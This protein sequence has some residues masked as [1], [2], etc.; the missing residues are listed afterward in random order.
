[1]QNKLIS[2]INK[3]T[4]YKAGVELDIARN[5]TLIYGTYSP[6]KDLGYINNYRFSINNNKNNF[7]TFSKLLYEQTYNKLLN[8]N[9]RTIPVGIELNGLHKIVIDIDTETTDS[10]QIMFP[11]FLEVR[12]ILKQ[13]FNCNVKIFTREPTKKEGII[14]DNSAIEGNSYKYGCHIIVDKYI[15][16]E[17][18][19]CTYIDIINIPRIKELIEKYGNNFIDPAV[20]QPHHIFWLFGSCKDGSKMYCELNDNCSLKNPFG[21]EYI[22]LQKSFEQFCIE[23]KNFEYYVDT[24][25]NS[26]ICNLK[27]E[28]KNTVKKDVSTPDLFDIPPPNIVAVDSYDIYTPFHTEQQVNKEVVD[29][30]KEVSSNNVHLDIK[31]LDSLL[32]L[33]DPLS[34]EDYPNVRLKI[35][36]GVSREYN[37]STESWE[38]LLKYLQLWNQALGRDINYHIEPIKKSFFDGVPARE[39]GISLGTVRFLAS[40]QNHAKYEEWCNDVF[41]I[42]FDNLYNDECEFNDEGLTSNE[43]STEKSSRVNKINSAIEDRATEKTSNIPY[44]SVNTVQTISRFN[45]KIL[46]NIVKKHIKES[47]EE[48]EDYINDRQQ[49]L[50]LFIK[51]FKDRVFYLK[52]PAN[53]VYIDG[54]IFKKSDVL[55]TYE[56]YG[57]IP[58]IKTFFKNSK[59]PYPAVDA[60]SFMNKCQYRTL[61]DKSDFI[62]ING[63]PSKKIIEQDG[64]KILNTFTGYNPKIYSTEQIPDLTKYETLIT[65]FINYHIGDKIS[66]ENKDYVMSHPVWFRLFALT[67]LNISGSIEYCEYLK[68]FIAQIIQEPNTLLPIGLLFHSRCRQGKGLLIKMISM[69]IGDDYVIE[70]NTKEDLFGTHAVPFENRLLVNINE[71]KSTQFGQDIVDIMKSYIDGDKLRTANRKNI[72]QYEYTIKARII[73]TTNNLNGFSFDTENGNHRFNAF[74]SYNYMPD[75]EIVYNIISKTIDVWKKSKWF[76]RELYNYFNTIKFTH[77]EVLHIY[78]TPYLQAIIDAS[79]SPVKTWLD[80]LNNDETVINYYKT[81]RKIEEISINNIT[82]D[83]IIPAKNLWIAFN[84][85]CSD[86]YISSKMTS[87]SFYLELNKYPEIVKKHDVKI[88]NLVCYH[89]LHNKCE[90]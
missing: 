24:Y 7:L 33:I 46:S 15:Y 70:C 13:Y 78:N 87:K 63:I 37:Q 65:E 32:A 3:Q 57:K 68:K 45:E 2:F 88:H 11:I 71:A 26:F 62:P 22:Q 81:S 21:I 27:K 40:E 66:K 76:Y 84:R 17:D 72:Q 73:A 61:C 41:G 55:S 1:M 80:Q 52:Y 53:S 69:I 5:N 79:D 28:S 48:E 60:F 64:Y 74:T 23:N 86:S 89:L 75:Q 18:A 85:F 20:F 58:G 54:K 10:I 16:Q 50:N 31:Y 9:Y 44:G 38:I 4:H 19:K 59:L 39:E 77:N 34:T 42:D 25:T 43:L 47:Y 51:Y 12:D 67:M 56:G 82:D 6:P 8:P 36:A 29:I 35:I 30:S 83:C 90:L 49:V 14:K